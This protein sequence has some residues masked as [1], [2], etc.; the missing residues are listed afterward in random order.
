MP[1]QLLKD[2]E[3]YVII[4][5]IKQ[6]AKVATDTCLEAETIPVILEKTGLEL[7]VRMKDFFRTKDKIRDY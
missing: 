1:S 2:S 3:G 5:M 4:S 6:P 7:N